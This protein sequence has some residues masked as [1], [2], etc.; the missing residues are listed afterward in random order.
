M[1]SSSAGSVDPRPSDDESRDVA[2]C[3]AAF[4]ARGRPPLEDP[5]RHCRH[6]L[7]AKLGLDRSKAWFGAHA[8]EPTLRAPPTARVHGSRTHH[9]TQRPV[10]GFEDRALHRQSCTL[11]SRGHNSTHPRGDL[12]RRGHPDVAPGA[13]SSERSCLGTARLHARRRSRAR[14]RTRSCLGSLWHTRQETVGPDMPARAGRWAG[15]RVPRSNKRRSAREMDTSGTRNARRAVG[16]GTRRS[17]PSPRRLK[18]ST[19]TRR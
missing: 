10:S 17:R 7:T 12:A 3:D 4:R 13:A 15:S 16:R 11:E 14:G 5:K 19:R 18:P 9:G 1:T 6:Q 8:C 2:I